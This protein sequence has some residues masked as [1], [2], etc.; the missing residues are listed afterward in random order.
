MTSAR[1]IELAARARK[2]LALMYQELGDRLNTLAH[3]N[4]PFPIFNILLAAILRMIRSL[5]C[6]L[7]C[8]I[9]RGRPMA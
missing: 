6:R 4:G 7:N 8:S 3:R 2:H 9:Y 1:D 5:I